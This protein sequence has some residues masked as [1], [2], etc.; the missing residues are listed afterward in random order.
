MRLK[1]LSLSKVR[2]TTA[3]ILI[4]VVIASYTVLS[5]ESK[6]GK[7]V[8][9]G[10]Y[11][12]MP[13]FRVETGFD[14]N[15]YDRLTELITGSQGLMERTRQCTNVDPYEDMIY[16][17][18]ECVPMMTR[19]VSN[20]D[21][22]FDWKVDLDCDSSPEKVFNHFVEGYK[23]CD[24]SPGRD[25]I[26]EIE[27]QKPGMPNGEF[28]IEMR[29]QEG[30]TKFKMVKPKEGRTYLLPGTVYFVDDPDEDSIPLE[31]IETWALY[32]VEYKAG[33]VEKSSYDAS[34]ILP[35]VF[36]PDT[37]L[38]DYGIVRLYKSED[39]RLAFLAEEDYIDKDLQ[40]NNMTKC[41]VS[42]NTYRFCV[43][44]LNKDGDKATVFTINPDTNKPEHLPI[45]YRFALYFP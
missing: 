1:Q 28:I 14:A 35:D 45:T 43:S 16:T 2:I 8:F 15:D 5:A 40:L 22:G 39:G 24:E 6:Q 12:F 42:K 26:C 31:Q 10:S 17:L 7:A 38:S 29:P 18:E 21:E 41:E 25:C 32:K 33:V 23:L 20:I 4:A 11:T 13:T 44:K 34:W 19:I 9:H 37:P 36:S 30:Q 3:V 27:M